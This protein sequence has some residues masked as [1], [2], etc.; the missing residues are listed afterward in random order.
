MEEEMI[1][2]EGVSHLTADLFPKKRRGP[3]V[4]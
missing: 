1:V 3:R 2:A 4:R